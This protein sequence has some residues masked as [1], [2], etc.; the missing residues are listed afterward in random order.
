MKKLLILYMLLL[1]V[2]CTENG[3]FHQVRKPADNSRV[4]HTAVRQ[5]AVTGPGLAISV[6]VNREIALHEATIPTADELD[7]SATAK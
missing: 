2:A 3:E 1:F 5:Q 6:I 4:V 7:E